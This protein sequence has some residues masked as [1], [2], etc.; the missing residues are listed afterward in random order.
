MKLKLDSKEVTKLINNIIRPVLI[1]NGFKNYTGRKYWRYSSEKIDV[2]SF[3]SFNSYNA[4]VLG[5]TT[6]SFAV[7]LASF[8]NYI[9]SDTQFKEKKGLKR[10]DESQ[11]YFR[12][13][14]KKSI[15][16]KEF[17]R[18]DIWLI[19]EKGKYLVNAINDC[20]NQIE[21]TAFTWFS[22]FEA[23]QEVLRI[24]KEDD[25]DMKETW[26]FGN[27]DSPNR[28]KLIAYTA[29]SLGETNL[30]IEK[31]EKLKQYYKKEYDQFKYKYYL[32]KVKEINNEISRLQ[33]I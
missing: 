5:C 7:N 23:K 33:L 22:K 31:F 29:V 19:D 16:Q 6:F 12:R 14:I 25:N 8:L 10:P 11:G 4:E 20:K 28:N 26:G 18:E 15:E 24:L 30:A 32:D 27:I 21:N 13:S 9:P 2:I 3:Q 17:P 1:E